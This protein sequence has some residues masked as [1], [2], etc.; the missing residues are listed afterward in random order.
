MEQVDLEGLTGLLRTQLQRAPLRMR[1]QQN[2]LS[3]W[4]LETAS[5]QGPGAIVLVELPSGQR[6]FRG[7]GVYLGWEQVRLDKVWTAL[8][9]ADAG[10]PLFEPLQLG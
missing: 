2:T 5:T 3:A 1:E 9:V 10:E 4:R 8:A 6:T 7:E